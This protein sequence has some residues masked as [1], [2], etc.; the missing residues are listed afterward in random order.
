M[1]KNPKQTSDKVASLAAATL[2]DEAASK[3]QKRLAG[4][5]LSQAHTGNAPSPEI[6]AI[7]ARVL[8]N[9]RSAEETLILAGSV[10]SQSTK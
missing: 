4:S 8:N 3:V 9:P 10:L 7:A 1:P 2:R 6:E 5:A